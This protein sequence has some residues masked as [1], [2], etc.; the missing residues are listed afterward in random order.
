MH[1]YDDLRDDPQIR[2]NQLFRD[3][4]VPGGTGTLVNHPNRY[5]GEVPP[6]RRLASRSARKSAGAGRAGY[7]AAGSTTSWRA[8]RSRPSKEKT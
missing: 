6:L 8:A 4:P 3:V 5:D 2:H 7:G 1:Q